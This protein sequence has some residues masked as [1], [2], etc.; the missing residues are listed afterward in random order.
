[1]RSA[2]MVDLP[3]PDEP[4]IAT[5]F[6]GGRVRLKSFNI[7]YMNQLKQHKH[8]TYTIEMR[9]TFFNISIQLLNIQIKNF[10]EPIS[11]LY[12]LFSN[13][14]ADIIVYLIDYVNV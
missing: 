4:T 12:L 2:A 13:I 10:L 5:I 1:M 14:L 3:L 11:K 7:T 6:P 9:D 8:L